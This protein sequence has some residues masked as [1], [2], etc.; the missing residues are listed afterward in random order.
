MKK[1]GTATLLLVLTVFTV[2]ISLQKNE[3]QLTFGIEQEFTRL[4][5][6]I[7]GQFPKWIQG[8]LVRNSS[9]PLFENGKQISHPFDGLAMLHGF[10]FDNG[11]VAY[12]NKFLKS[13]DYDEAK[14]GNP[15]FGGFASKPKL[16]F[17]DKI[18]NYFTTKTG[19][20]NALVNVF[21][22]GKSTVALTETPLPVKFDI[23]SLN[24][25]GSFQ[26]QDDL[27]KTKCWECA[28]P[29]RDAT[30]NEIYNY[31]IEIGPVSRYVLY[32]IPQ[33]TSARE[34][35]AKIPVSFPSYM[36]SFSMTDHYLVLTEY[37]L[38][39]NPQALMEGKSL[40]ES[41]FWDPEKRS[42]FLVVD[43]ATGKTISETDTDPFFSFHHANA[44]EEGENLIIDLVSYPDIST[45]KS[46]FIEAPVPSATDK[47]KW[48]QR[49]VRYRYSIKDHHVSPQVL[50]EM[51]VEFP[52]LNDTL[53]SRPYRF[54]YLT[55]TEEGAGGVMKVDTKTGE[56]KTWV[57]KETAA[58]EPI[59]V[60][61]PQAAEEDEGVVLTVVFNKEHN[62]AFLL[63]LNAKT[64]LEIGRAELPFPIPE[65]FHGQFFHESTFIP[66]Q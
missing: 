12:T 32:R 59:F 7:Q 60:P 11:Q 54:L 43:K 37:P 63:G 33:G 5:L 16:T 36:H 56:A 6:N 26:Y 48:K 18:Q 22:Y 52:R 21:L 39:I 35:I 53:D 19:V 42:H 38:F 20:A 61:S 23:Y 14:R 64:F 29:H 62:Q 40:A 15:H 27:P 47:S 66:S 17:W 8:T 45:M 44:Y 10:D 4:P 34:P 9:V 1:K 49:L 65:S 24:T 3:P 58:I 51:D 28:H 41:M 46:I 57:Q 25:L 13:D 31:L 2:W 30:T 50:L 55:S